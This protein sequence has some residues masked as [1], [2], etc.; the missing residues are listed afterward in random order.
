MMEQIAEA[1]TR[2]LANGRIRAYAA[3]TVNE[4]TSVTDGMVRS[5]ESAQGR[6]CGVN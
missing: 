2:G 5:Q 6:E 4:R 1:K 3:R